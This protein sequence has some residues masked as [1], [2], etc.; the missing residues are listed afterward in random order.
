MQSVPPPGLPQPPPPLDTRRRFERALPSFDPE[1]QLQFS[2]SAFDRGP[3]N[4]IAVPLALLLAWLFTGTMLG[5]IFG[6]LVGMPFH[7]LGHAAMA[8]LSSR[9]AVPL[10]FFTLWY[11]NQSVLV[12]L[13]VSG[14]VSYFAFLAYREDNRFAV[15]CCAVTLA[16]FLG[17]SLGLSAERTL[18]WEILAGVLGEL[19]FSAF[20]LVAFH[21][22]MPDRL[23]WDFWRWIAL[24]P[25]AFAFTQALRLWRGVSADPTQMPWGSA[26]G[27]ESDGDMYRLV[28]NHG[29]NA[30]SLA[31]FYAAM[32]YMCLLTIGAAY[33]YA[34]WRQRGS[35]LVSDLGTAEIRDG[36]ARR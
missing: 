8:W 24:L 17:V 4:L 15:T 23:R 27:S 21:F 13:L 26:V 36:H 3:E 29:W 12:G 16:A 28:S 5:R 33:A 6:Y 1:A 25:A 18:G 34:A 30:Q 32:G 11:E 31:D 9:P 35:E 19:G 20:V 14:T 10:P 2:R 7:E 22:P